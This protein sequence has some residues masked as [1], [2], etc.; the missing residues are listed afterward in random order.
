[1]I[2]VA[3]HIC[4]DVTPRL[5]S[6]AA[7]APGALVEAGPAAFSAGGA[8][9]NVG[10]TL[11]R[12]GFAATLV[13]L[14]GDDQFGAILQEELEVSAA[15]SD[16]SVELTLT[17]AG[18][19]SYSIVIAQPG[20][21]RCFLHHP[22]CNDAFEPEHLQTQRW[23]QAELLHFGY[24]SLMQGLYRDKGA[25]LAAEFSR[26]R[27]A[28][29][30]VS[31]DMAM[32]DP[33]GESGKVDWR[34][35]MRTVLPHVDLFLPSWDEIWYMHYPDRDPADLTLERL[36]SVATDLLALGPAVVG[37]KLGERGLYLRSASS[38]RVARAGRRGLPAGWADR[39]LLSPNMSVNAQGTTGAGDAT[40]AGL[41][42]AA[43]DE[44]PLDAVATFA[45]AVGACSVEGSGAVGGIVSRQQTAK[46]VGAGW[47]R[48]DT[49]RGDELT[50]A[51]WRRDPASGVLFGPADGGGTS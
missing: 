3:G 5:A 46:R 16:V 35:F 36:A 15:A 47:P 38:D 23:L 42:A 31:L 17:T 1:M 7:L 13:G 32:P 11:A 19:T 10:L 25:G 6:A 2:V 28:G 33:H 27:S 12:L 24:P 29:V 18:S 30:V 8:V 45:S 44:L 51:G 4:L 40:I 48:T 34:E 21:D 43:S 20:R 41:L 39:E 26:L 50:Q 22:G 14:A 49:W 9:A 37:L